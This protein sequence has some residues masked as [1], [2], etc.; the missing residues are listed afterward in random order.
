MELSDLPEP[1]PADPRHGHAL[2]DWRG[3]PAQLSILAGLTALYLE[4]S[5]AV[6]IELL[7]VSKKPHTAQL[8]LSL[9][10][11]LDE[12]HHSDRQILIGRLRAAAL[13]Y[14]ERDATGTTNRIDGLPQRDWSDDA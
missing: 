4:G 12:N 11:L 9:L 2:D 3:T 8:V 6:P 13:L 5:T 7:R 14:A 10:Q 1:H